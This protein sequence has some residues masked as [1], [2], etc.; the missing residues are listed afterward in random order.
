MLYRMLVPKLNLDLS[1]EFRNSPPDNRFELWRLLNRKLG[2][3]RADWA[4]HWTNDLRKHARTSCT[5]FGQTV[6]FSHRYGSLSRFCK[7][8]VG[9]TRFTTQD[10]A[11][12]G[13][14]VANV[15]ATITIYIITNITQTV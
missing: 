4:F 2:P 8:H 11:A 13:A 14:R 15:G 3:Q 1:T 9:Q 5:D 12:S 6:K 10:C 7:T